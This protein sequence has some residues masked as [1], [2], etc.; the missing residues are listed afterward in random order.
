MK[1]FLFIIL[2]LAGITSAVYAQDSDD[3]ARGKFAGGIKIGGNYSNVYDSEGEDFTAD[4]RIGL[5]TGGFLHIPIGKLIG[6]QPEILFSQ[7][8]FNGTGRISGVSYD[9]KRTT[10]YL[11]VPVFFAV[12]PMPQFTLL[13]GPQFSYLMSQRDELSHPSSTWTIV[14]EKEFENEDVRKNTL[15]FVGGFDINIDHAV[16]SARAGWDLQNNRSDGSSSIPRYKNVWVQAT[17]GLRLY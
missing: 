11:D 3:D 4:G 7:K 1:K 14:Q 16:L 6:I 2:S 13:A 8:G 17:I 10:N 5:A 9:L 12:K 15:C